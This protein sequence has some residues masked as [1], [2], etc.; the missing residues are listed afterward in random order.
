MKQ[1]HQCGQPLAVKITTCPTCGAEVA[2][3]LQSI[4]NYRILSVLHEGYSSV[5]CHAVNH[6]TGQEVALRIFTPQSGVDDKIA[7]R[8]TR[9]LEILKELPLDY[10][11]RHLEI[12]RSEKGLWYRVSEWIDAQNWGQLF[13]SDHFSDYRN[14]FSL[15]RKMASILDG[16]HQIG[17]AIPHLIL[18][19][20]IVFED[21]AGDLG[22][23]ID[24]K[25][26]RFLD[27]QLDRPGAML[28]NLL[29]T[30]PDTIH[31]RPLNRRSDIWSLGKIFV[32][33]LSGDLSGDIDYVRTIDQLDIPTK[34]KMLFK[35]MLSD[36]RDL[37]PA[38]MTQVVQALSQIPDKQIFQAQ[39]K[40]TAGDISGLKRWLRLTVALLVIVGMIVVLS[41]LYFVYF[42]Q[43]APT[44]SEYANRYAGSVAF[45]MVDYRLL[46][47]K[48]QVYH[49]RTEGTAFL[50][51]SQGHLITNRH[52]AC[53][54]L[55]DQRM[56]QMIT[57]LKQAGHT[58]RLDYRAFLWFEGQKAFK[59][60]P[61]T[62]RSA[63][64][65]D[66]Y[67][68]E[69]AYR[70]TGAKKLSIAGVAH[71]PA[72]TWQVV[73]SP[74]K[75]DFAVL[76]IEPIPEART[77]L[78]LDNQMAAINIPKLTPVMTL[79]FP[80]G[81]R[82]QT[83]MVNVSVSTGHV[84]RTFKTMFQVDTSIYQGNSGGPVIDPHGR[85]VGIASSVY[86]N[87][88]RSPVPVIT[89]LSDIGLVLPVNKAAIFLTE[90]QKGQTKWNGYLDLAI[91]E[92][93]KKIHTAAEKGEWNKAL[94]LADNAF[95][96]NNN[97]ALALTAGLIHYCRN[98][99][100]AAQ[101]YFARA[102]S[103]NHDNDQARMFLYFIDYLTHQH[104]NS[105]HRK[106]LLALDWRSPA[107]FFGFITKV[108]TEEIDIDTAI[109]M[110]D[111]NQETSMLYYLAGLVFDQK[112]QSDDAIN[113]F[114][115][116][117]A[118]ID[119]SDRWLYLMVMAKLETLFQQKLTTLTDLVQR[120]AYQT[121]T[122]AVIASTRNS[123]TEKRTSHAQLAL[124]Y[125]ELKQSSVSPSE[126]QAIIDKIQAFDQKNADLLVQSAYYNAMDGKWEEALAQIEKL[127]PTTGRENAPRLGGGLL[128]PLLLN[129][130]GRSAEAKTR[131]KTFQERIQDSWYRQI[132]AC[133]LDPSKEVSL[134]E[135]AGEQPAYLLTGHVALGLWAEG[136]NEIKQ[137]LRHYKEA[138]GSYR[139]DRIEYQFAGER[140]R[141]LQQTS[142]Q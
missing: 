64:L 9:E 97:P 49:N 78:P 108:L 32:E 36:D 65:E 4:D 14:V 53:P 54:W 118:S 34:A 99:Y 87:Q 127:L 103:M 69:N 92:K 48:R 133:L 111:T 19:D 96:E 66:F 33:I 12:K 109:H 91:D 83:D 25:V 139:D 46:L 125:A 50:V 47:E 57:R 121:E 70:L 68:T 51:S 62:A 13:T 22:V 115:K 95:A 85:V 41:W 102:L 98:D 59:R 124:L 26:S 122:N 42:K 130:V 31:Q 112:G 74:L 18:N 60:L 30:H 5:V 135:K 28:K 106:A 8:L 72:N 140:I 40:G 131:L 7:A 39:N 15:F 6:E 71:P 123:W 58:P 79:G 75:D 136:N 16:L 101:S 129:C 134:T 1:C 45:V 141:Q 104:Q 117:L 35:S 142:V 24:Y 110:G 67:H 86:T 82:T 126:K 52:V 55:E 43:E 107:E 89:M 100:P 120:K 94:N 116:A 38:N 10:F 114:Q 77:P 105:P 73:Q 29:E 88:A 137:A 81:S 113:F 93:L 119:G 37:R 17:H 90:I 61:K 80:L 76:K 63:D 44:L 132:S 20:I 56:F 11:V 128:Q 27:P 138:L 21:D 3:G 84:R 2:E 23:K